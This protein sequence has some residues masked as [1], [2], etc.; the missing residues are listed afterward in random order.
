MTRL[1]GKGD[2][3]PG[4]GLCIG[5]YLCPSCKRDHQVFEYRA[6]DGF[7]LCGGVWRV[8]PLGSIHDESVGAPEQNM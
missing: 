2:V 3:V 7:C 5:W 8:V 1:V 4:F 6:Q